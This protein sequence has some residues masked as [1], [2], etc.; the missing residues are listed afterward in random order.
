MARRAQGASDPRRPVNQEARRKQEMAYRLFIAGA[1]Y[2][3]IAD[4]GDPARPGE[5]L[6]GNKG[7]A[8]NAVQSAIE[9]HS[10]FYDAEQ[11]R[12]VEAQRIDALQRALW[13]KALNGDPWAVLRCKELMERRAALFGLD[14]PKRQTVE[15]ISID[16]VQD[17]INQL[18]TEMAKMD[19]QDVV[20]DGVGNPVP[21]EDR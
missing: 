1:S 20:L 13:P 19:A 18:T 2:A 12:I 16:A 3:Q 6:Y 11:M 15:V 21:G 4:A 8:Y 7:T 17:A 14:A 9:R 5:T 10:G